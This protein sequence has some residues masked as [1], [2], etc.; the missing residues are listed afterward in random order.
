MDLSEKITMKY[1]IENMTCEGCVR[2]VRKVLS[3]VDP[4]A[5]V[6]IDLPIREVEIKSF[7]PSSSFSEALKAAGFQAVGDEG[8]SADQW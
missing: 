5:E 1:Q 7:R 4:D 8:V 2:R 3:Q 6:A